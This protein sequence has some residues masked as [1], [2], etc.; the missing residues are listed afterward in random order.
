[1][2]RSFKESAKE[3]LIS[4]LPL[5]YCHL[6]VLKGTHGSRN[7][8]VDMEEAG[9]VALFYILQSR[10]FLGRCLDISPYNTKKQPNL[11]TAPTQRLDRAIV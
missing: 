7:N 5:Q 4:K 11:T 10:F 3:V 6:S 8:Q 9:I 1:M 2:A